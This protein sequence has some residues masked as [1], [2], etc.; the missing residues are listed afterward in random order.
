MLLSLLLACGGPD[1]AATTD[2][3]D[4]APDAGCADVTQVAG[5]GSVA[6]DGTASGLRYCW[7]TD[8]A[9][10]TW[11]RTAAVACQTDPRTHVGACEVT[12]AA[13]ECAEDADC[14]AGRFCGADGPGC[15]CYDPCIDDD[16]CGVGN[17]CLCAVEVY[18]DTT[19][20]LGINTC[21]PAE[22]RTG[23]DCTSGTC[24][25]ALD[26]CGEVVGLQCRA[27]NDA[28]RDDADC[29]GGR[30]AWD[31]SAF[32]CAAEGACE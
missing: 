17:A 26:A 7:D 29:D 6:G 20:T 3:K 2:P 13:S 8:P 30:C 31:G 27:A 5:A 14:G 12:D 9:H 22:C 32:A 23:A 21:V 15:A 18:A 28:C 25:V 16:D 4:T 10:G 1:G 19:H 11:D 24:G